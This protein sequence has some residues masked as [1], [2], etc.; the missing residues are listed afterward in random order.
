MGLNHLFAI[1]SSFVDWKVHRKLYLV[2]L[3]LHVREGVKDYI[4][5]LNPYPA[6]LSF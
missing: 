6:R 3:T 4:F 5:I 1:Y 2:Y